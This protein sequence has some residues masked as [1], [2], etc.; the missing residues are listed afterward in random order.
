MKNVL[1]LIAILFVISCSKKETKSEKF[2]Q[3][4]IKGL[5]IDSTKHLPV[6]HSNIAELNV[7]KMFNP[8]PFNFAQILESV[9]CIP[10]ETK[11]ECLISE[12]KSITF[13]KDY[14]YVVDTYQ[15]GG[16]VIF[17]KTGKFIKR[18]ERGQAPHEITLLKNICYND[19]TN[20]LI[21]FHSQFMSFYTPKG[22]FIKKTKLSIN[23]YS[24]EIINDGYLFYTIK[25]IDN[26]HIGK[27]SDCRLL[28]LN[29][30]FE[31]MYAGKNSISD[32]ETN[33]MGH[34]RY[35]KR[36][37]DTIT[38]SFPFNDT[39]FTY[40]N[41]QI[42]AKTTLNIGRSSV[43]RDVLGKGEKIIQM[44]LK[45]NNYDFF[46]GE[47]ENTTTHE[48][49]NLSNFHTKKYTSVF[50]D[51]R[52]NKCISLNSFI[53]PEYLPFFREPIATFNDYFVSY[54]NP[55]NIFV[56]SLFGKTY[57]EK[58]NIKEFDNPILVFYK[59]KHF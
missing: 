17:H 55:D 8:K 49:F 30:N 22:K 4:E 29:T 10:L 27:Y 24:F 1:Y 54:V 5:K 57:G 18:I 20:E 47:F 36:D 31:L 7:E 34:T 33:F 12:L 56:N 44:E 46:L 28:V 9:M 21:V 23:A 39:I 32:I 40:F 59:L 26:R 38:I 35:L 50:R 25:G 11:E 15:N 48:F 42:K 14:I 43:P 45:A 16:I 52:S 51:K 58:N 3:V 2:T 19:K 13:S 37:K 6:D 53:F 41:H